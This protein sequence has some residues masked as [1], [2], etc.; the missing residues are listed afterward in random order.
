MANKHSYAAKSIRT[1]FVLGSIAFLSA[2]SAILFQVAFNKAVSRLGFEE[3][4]KMYGWLLSPITLTGF[5]SLYFAF[6]E[7]VLWKYLSAIPCLSGTWVGFTLPSYQ[8]WPHLIV[9]KIDQT[10]SDICIVIYVFYKNSPS[11]K[12]GP[13]L[14]MLGI[15]DSVTACLSG[16]S[17][18]EVAVIIAYKHTG[19]RQSYTENNKSI[20][21]QPDF[22]GTISAN[23]ILSSP[24][25][26]M[27]GTVYTNRYDENTR[28][29]GSSGRLR[30]MRFKTKKT[31]PNDIYADAER[32]GIIEL[33]EK[34][35]MTQ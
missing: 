12:W 18:N 5:Y 29:Y 16:K 30:L 24:N 19:M 34:E 1:S 10:W 31:D 7:Y 27:I 35:I 33:L 17:N 22:L 14:K 9:M 4:A 26:K 15:D 13:N 28:R 6:F 23:T 32:K 21:R 3:S 11:E 2:V 8:D 25:Y 20:S